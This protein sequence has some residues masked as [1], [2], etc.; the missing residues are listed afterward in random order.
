VAYILLVEDNPATAE[1]VVRTL[2][3]VHIEVRHAPTG[4][5]SAQIARE[6]RPALILMDFGLPDI[7]GKTMILLLKKQLGG[8]NAPPFVAVTAHAD[9]LQRKIAEGFGCAAFVGKP[10]TPAEL[11]AVIFHVSRQFARDVWPLRDSV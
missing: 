8:S 3:A 5:A 6:E 4:L 7:D 10:F 11:L 9:V 2:N 1:L